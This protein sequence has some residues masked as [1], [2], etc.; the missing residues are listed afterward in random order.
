MANTPWHLLTQTMSVYT[1]TWS[2][3]A[4]GVP[5]G[6]QPADPSFSVACSVQ[7]G[8]AADGLVYGRDTTTKIVEIYAAPTTT[9]GAAWTVTPKDRVIIAGVTYRVAGQP[10]DLISMGTVYVVTLERDQ[11]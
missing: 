10:R 8:S 4:D 7:P 3:G 6:L 1:V 2:G 11:D 9:A 5:S